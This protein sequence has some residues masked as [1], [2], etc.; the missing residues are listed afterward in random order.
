MGL[1][2]QIKERTVCGSQT[3]DVGR[4]CIHEAGRF[5]NLYKYL[6]SLRKFSII[7]PLGQI[8]NSCLFKGWV[9]LLETRGGF[10]IGVKNEF[11]W[12]APCR[13]PVVGPWKRRPCMSMSNSANFPGSALRCVAHFIADKNQ[14]FPSSLDPGNL[15]SLHFGY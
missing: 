3:G 9:G 6:S 14:R 7:F 11:F 10:S 8:A 13:T 12:P 4:F 15:L 1:N 5:W 2:N